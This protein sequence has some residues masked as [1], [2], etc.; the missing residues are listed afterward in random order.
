MSGDAILA[1]DL[2]TSGLRSVVVDADGSATEAATATYAT[3]RPHPAWAEQDPEEWWEALVQTTR[4]LSHRHPDLWKAVR[5]V[6]ITGQSPGVV[7]VDDS[8]EPVG[9]AMIWQ[10]RRATGESAE[11]ASVADPETWLSWTGFERG[12]DPGFR[13][14]KLKWI[15]DHEPHRIEA[16]R[17]VLQPKD[18]LIFRLTGRAVIDRIAM[19]GSGLSHAPGGLWDAVGLPVDLLPEP[20]DPTDVAGTVSDAGATVPGLRGLPVFAG[21]FDGLCGIFGSGPTGAGEAVNVAGTSQIAVITTAAERSAPGLSVKQLAPEMWTLGGPTQSGGAA[22]VA[23]M[24]AF[25]FGDWSELESAARTAPPGSGELLFLPFLDG[26]R[27]PYWNSELRGGLVGLASAHDRAHVARA[28]IEGCAL[29]VADI[30]DRA[31]R[32]SGVAVGHLRCSGGMARSEV[33]LRAR[34]DMLGLPVLRPHTV[35]ASAMGAAILGAVGLGWF[36]DPL[37]AAGELIRSDEAATPEPSFDGA[38]VLERYREAVAMQLEAVRSEP[39]R[40]T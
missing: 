7:L 13:P 27:A 36:A 21:T 26:E 1:V 40:S 33:S 12:N 20:V 10:D 35:E 32:G 8:G 15:V 9:P 4:S 22:I 37:E 19:H 34:A 11:L 6:V 24:S 28:V 2:G 25:G 16:T 29:A 14:A 38:S 39:G 18:Y 23:A 17:W 3:R 5:G 31:V 30:V